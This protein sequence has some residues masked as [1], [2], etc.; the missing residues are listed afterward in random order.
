[1]PNDPIIPP[2]PSLIYPPS[3]PGGIPDIV[4]FTIR[5]TPSETYMVEQLR[6]WVVNT[7][8]PY[9]N[10]A[11]KD[12]SQ[13]WKDYAELLIAAWDAR[14]AQMEAELA[15]AVAS[16]G[17]RVG[18]AEAAKAAAQAAQ[19]AAEA[20]RDQAA[21]YASQAEEIQD[22]AISG[23]VNTP[24]SSTREMLDSL[25][26][27]VASVSSL[28]VLIAA[29]TGTVN[30]HGTELSGRLSDTILA[31]TYRS[32]IMVTDPAFGAV[33]DGV[34]DDTAHIQA[35]IDYANA[36]GG[37][38]VTVPEG[39]YMISADTGSSIWTD[40]GGIKMKDNVTLVLAQ[41]AVLRAIPVTTPVSKI[42]RV[43][44]VSNVS[45]LGAGTIDGNRANAVVATGEWGYGVSLNGSQNVTLDGF[46]SIN[47]WGDGINLQRL[48]LADFTSPK[49]VLI[50]NVICDNNRR[51]G[52]SIEDGV[53]IV[54]ENG[55]FSNTLGALPMC[56]IDIEPPDGN[57]NVSNVTL[58]NNI[59]RNNA[60]RGVTVAESAR[61]SN[62][63]IDKCTFDS[64]GNGGGGA[65][66]S[67]FYAIMAGSGL[68]IRDCKFIGSVIDDCVRVDGA[69]DGV[70]ITNC[71]ID[72]NLYLY[73]T[74]LLTGFPV[75]SVVSNN[76]IRGTIK[77]QYQSFI[78]IVDNTILPPDASNGID[79][80]GTVTVNH[81]KITGNMIRGGFNGIKLNAA[82]PMTTGVIANNIL[83]NQH[84]A[85]MILTGRNIIV[86]DN[87]ITGA[88]LDS[89]TASVVF[90]A[91][92]NGNPYI[93]FER[94]S[95]QKPPF[96]SGV[97][98]NVP[99][100]AINIVSTMLFG[101]VRNNRVDSTFT[102]SNGTPPTGN[103]TLF[104]NDD[105]PYITT[106][107]RPGNA[108]NGTMVFDTTL[109]KPVWRKG[110]VW[111]D[112][113]GATV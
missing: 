28:N 84:D 38:V 111:V 37:G 109:G 42:I 112:S 62:V 104:A 8:V 78:N 50:R 30:D 57:G 108:V 35:A 74:A 95:I 56:G 70:R 40:A 7:L 15:E 103:G 4:P 23:I 6:W 107:Q 79:F 17:D 83:V 100:Y 51:Q 1:M 36:A 80:S 73:G 63:I 102:F 75:G 85:A 48:A 64:N 53:D 13:G 71:D 34:V 65:A 90:P 29:L 89:G 10:N 99:A 76:T 46:R 88:C 49:N 41:G 9:V 93:A 12:L 20:A 113:A 96:G 47:C 39:V 5:E 77:C 31:K 110:S 43:Y 87:T 27:S 54:V 92:A 97:A 91:D 68:S 11:V 106:G 21:I 32:S 24:D 59:F 45:I 26:A 2:I 25:Y 22:V 60:R 101:R 82:Q 69:K 14:V 58:R 67:Q 81:V 52:L 55:L 19:A 105:V 86:T 98:N 72:K 61:V 66:T 3:L 44:N 94:N 18:E 33:G 16:I